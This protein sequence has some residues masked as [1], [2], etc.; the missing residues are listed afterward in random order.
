M[1]FERGPQGGRSPWTYHSKT[2]KKTHM[3]VDRKQRLSKVNRQNGGKAQRPL[4]TP[5]IPRASSQLLV[6]ARIYSL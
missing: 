4:L 3:E 5:N 2:N 6:L 1:A